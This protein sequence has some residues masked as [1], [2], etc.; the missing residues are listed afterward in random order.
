MKA[1]TQ[2]HPR[3]NRTEQLLQQRGEYLEEIEQLEARVPGLETKLAELR[4]KVVHT[5]S[6]HIGNG[7]HEVMEDL[8]STRARIN[9]L[10]GHVQEI[11]RS[12]ELVEK[13]ESAAAAI[14]QAM[15]LINTEQR[16]QASLQARI[17]QAA[18]RSQGIEEEIVTAQSAAESAEQ[19]A[20][21]A[22]AQAED[23]KAEKAARTQLEKA[24]ELA[25][26]TE[27]I[28]RVKRRTI[29][30]MDGEVANMKQQAADSR[31]RE[32]VAKA[33]LSEALW[34]KY[35]EEWNA[36]AKTLASIGAHLVAA[37]RINGGWGTHL[38]KLHIPLFG[39]L[40]RET[41]TRT[42]VVDAS[43]EVSL[44]DLVKGTA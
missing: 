18:T 17:E 37:D 11:E 39:T 31:Q 12:L 32:Q 2:K 23:A 42:E 14:A 19:A 27:A 4:K 29:E 9:A 25:L 22:L 34:S 24:V 1:A 13:A 33:A 36:A 7:S 38:T 35:A 41:L 8:S 15:E 40:D 26:A 10:R 28:I 3:S 30:T 43:D 6:H 20:G 21:H 44:D 5:T 16:L